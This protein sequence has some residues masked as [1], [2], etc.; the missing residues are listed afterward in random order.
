MNVK[1]LEQILKVCKKYG[2]SHYKTPEL[3]LTCEV[4][5]QPVAAAQENLKTEPSY[6]DEDILLWSASN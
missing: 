1:E 6:T 2:V 3:E 4:L 5:D